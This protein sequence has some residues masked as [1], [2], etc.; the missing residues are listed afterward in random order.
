MIF[1]GTNL[2]GA[3]LRRFVPSPTSNDSNPLAQCAVI[4]HKLS[5]LE[6]LEHIILEIFALKI[7]GFWNFSIDCMPE[8]FF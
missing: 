6:Y 5:I 7:P 8:L 3:A 4:N 1:E 2:T